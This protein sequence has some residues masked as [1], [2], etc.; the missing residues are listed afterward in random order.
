MKRDVI[1]LGSLNMDLVMQINRLPN[2]GETLLGKDVEY[3]F[4]GKGA[5]QGVACSRFGGNVKFIG[6]VGDD[7]F[8]KAMLENM[9]K[10]NINTEAIKILENQSSGM[11]S[12]LKTKDDNAIVVIPGANGKCDDTFVEQYKDLIKKD[13]I[14]LTQLETPMCS[15]KKGLEIAKKQGA[16]TIL[17]PAPFMILDEDLYEFID[18]LTP[19]ESEFKLLCES[20]GIQT[21]NIDEAIKEWNS[22]YH[23]NIIVTRGA[24]GSSVIVDDEVKLIPN[25]KVDVVDTTGAGDTYNGILAACLAEGKDLSECVK[26]AGIGASLSVEGFGAQG[27]M[28]NREMVDKAIKER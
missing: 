16:T 10:E 9:N 24:D 2:I 3:Q 26:Y 18:Y 5:N 21:D 22:N 14:F 8:G 1:V 27:G 11:A 25:I 17:N 19:N 20:C 13:D 6:M 15:V 7:E 4:G 23:T 12:I 28:P